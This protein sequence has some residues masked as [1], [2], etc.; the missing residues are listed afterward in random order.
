MNL[1]KSIFSSVFEIIKNEISI[2]NGANKFLLLAI[3]ANI[4]S[5][6]IFYPYVTQALTIILMGFYMKHY[7]KNNINNAIFGIPKILVGL[8][9]LIL[10]VQL[11]WFPY[12]SQLVSI[13]LLT[14]IYKLSPRE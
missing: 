10:L 11:L 13:T 6:L 5:P 12:I 2:N 8:L 3:V 1:K 7:P 4:P 9:L 14:I